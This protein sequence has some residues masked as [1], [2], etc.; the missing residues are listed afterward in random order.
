VPRRSGFSSESR[1]TSA[2]QPSAPGTDHDTYTSGT[3]ADVN[4]ET[5]RPDRPVPPMAGTAAVGAV[6]QLL[7]TTQVEK[8]APAQAANL[9]VPGYRLGV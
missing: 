7:A 8:F 2:Y 6:V 1:S 5:R 9:V 4:P 3:L